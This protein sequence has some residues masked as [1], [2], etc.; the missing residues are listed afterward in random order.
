M[1]ILK[2]LFAGVATLASTAAAKAADIIQPRTAKVPAAAAPM[3]AFSWTGCHV[4]IHAGGGWGKQAVD[5]ARSSGG[6]I[7]GA[8][9]EDIHSSGALFGG[10]AGCDLDF[11]NGWVVGLEGDIAWADIDGKARDPFSSAGSSNSVRY[12]TQWLASA[13]G[14]LGYSA[15][16]PQT[17]IY[18]KGGVAW[19]HEKYSINSSISELDDKS[20]KTRTGWT[21]GGGIAWEFARNWSVFAEYNHYDFG[22]RGISKSVSFGPPF[23]E[24][25]QVAIKGGNIDTVKAGLNYRFG[26]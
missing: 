25:D 22:R 9:P 14:R 3:P 26:G 8:H 1:K 15:L 10:Q 2:L 18:A 16:L 23:F 4:G 5:A 12:D 24:F 7:T 19:I 17:L 21:V 6:S 20:E 13:T 11:A